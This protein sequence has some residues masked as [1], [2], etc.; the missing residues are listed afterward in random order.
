MCVLGR[1]LYVMMTYILFGMFIIYLV[2]LECIECMDVI[3]MLCV[4][5]DKKNVM[6]G[7]VSSVVWAF[8]IVCFNPGLSKKGKNMSLF[9]VISWCTW[10][11]EKFRHIHYI[12]TQ[13]KN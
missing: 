12:W 6:V 2:F 13:T 4:L 1:D 9:F 11:G 10:E 7:M 3:V 5:N 8:G